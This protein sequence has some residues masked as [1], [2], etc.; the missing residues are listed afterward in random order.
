MQYVIR[1]YNPPA[2]A[3]SHVKESPTNPRLLTAK[4]K[5]SNACDRLFLLTRI[6]LFLKLVQM[7]VTRFSDPFRKHKQ[8]KSVKLAN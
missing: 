2:Y 1:M 8:K 4:S 5:C 7:L 3:A 6:V